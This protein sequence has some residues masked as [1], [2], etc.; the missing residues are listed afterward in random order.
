MSLTYGSLFT[1]YGGLELGLQAVLGGTTAWHCDNAPGPARILAHHYPHVPNH[2]DITAVNWASVEP[3]DVLTGGFPCQDVSAAGKRA[4][5]RPG[6]RSGLWAHM[7]YAI[8]QLRPSLVV[9]ENVRGLLSA[10]ADSN[11]E[12]CPWCVGDNG[13]SSLRALGAVLGDLADL[14]YD[15][16]WTGVRARAAGAAHGRFRIFLFAAAA[17]T[18]SERYG[19]GQNPPTVGRVDSE[20]ASTARQRERARQV[21]SHRSATAWGHY[22]PAIRRWETTTGRLAPP[23]TQPRRDGQPRLA[24]PFVEW[25]MGLPAGHVTSP[26][27]GLTRDQQFTAL[28]NGVVPQQAALATRQWLQWRS[29]A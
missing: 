4:G 26:A 20:D 25:L 21:T 8:D 24:P 15:A 17:Y 12:P 5:L 6:T 10:S 1:G 18:G 7:A 29:A 28:G 2:G 14:R 27:I 19:G 3:V 11:V 23:P 16:W 9:A 13:S 22:E